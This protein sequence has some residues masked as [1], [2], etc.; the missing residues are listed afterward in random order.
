VRHSAKLLLTLMVLGLLVAACSGGSKSSDNN[1][2]TDT[3]KDPTPVP[4]PALPVNSEN[5]PLVAKVNGV[6]ITEPQYQRA[7][8]RRQMETG[9]ADPSVL[10][11]IVL[12]NLIE[13]VLIDQAA[14]DL[15]VTVS[16]EQLDTEVQSFVTDAG[17]A[18]NWQL[19]LNQNGYTSDEFRDALRGMMVTAQVQAA[20]VQ[21]VGGTA[22]HVHARHILV[23]TEAEAKDVL[24][25]LQ[26]GEDFAA[27]AKELSLDVTSAD[28][29]GDLG[30]FTENELLE[31][32]L[33][34]VAFSLL[35][36][37]IAGPVATRLGYHVI[38]TLAFE[39]RPVAADKAA[40]LAQIQFENWL[41]SMTEGATIERYLNQ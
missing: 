17:G 12:D 18:E 14:V 20:V 33:A 3:Q 8:A 9:A 32:S 15:G 36:G 5:I 35:P 34:Q 6:E 28:Q 25:R 39:D 30:W 21:N 26:A 16:D 27:L 22:P 1:T 38:Q 11:S 40:N 10:A 2:P 23:K 31:P 37:Q 24:A 19:W 29:G 7:L 41:Q 13:Q 4:A